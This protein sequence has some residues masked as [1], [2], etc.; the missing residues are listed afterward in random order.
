MEKL[1]PF[2]IKDMVWREIHH[3]HPNMPLVMVYV[4][5]FLERIAELERELAEAR[6]A[7]EWTRVEDGLP[8]KS[9]LSIWL[10]WVKNANKAGGYVELA[11]YGDYFWGDEDAN[12]GD[13]FCLPDDAHDS[14]NMG[15]SGWYREEETHGGL[16]DS[17]MIDLNDKVTHWK[18]KPDAPINPPAPDGS[19]KPRTPKRIQRRRT[20]GWRMPEGAVYVGRPTKWGNPFT[21]DEYGREEAISIFK[22]N[23][24]DEQKQNA[25]LELRGKDLACF[26][27]LDQPCH[28]DVLLELANASLPEERRQP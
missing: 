1:T 10:V 4:D 27:P 18:P 16:Y 25:R 9:E 5:R 14:C 20:K 21:V 13:P 2:E 6:K 17:I 7:A 11:S 23:L 12:P 15:S 8:E 28:A 24:T 26:C 22:Y 19:V 3:V